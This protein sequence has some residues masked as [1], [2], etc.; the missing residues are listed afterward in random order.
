MSSISP[1]SSLSFSTL[2]SSSCGNGSGLPL[3]SMMIL[4][5]TPPHWSKELSY[6][7]FL[8][9]IMLF[10]TI[11]TVNSLNL[12]SLFPEMYQ[13][14]EERAQAN[15]MRQILLMVGL[16]VAAI[17]PTLFIEELTGSGESNG[18]DTVTVGQYQIAGVVLAVVVFLCYAFGLRWGVKERPTFESDHLSVPESKT[19]FIQC[20]KNRNFQW[21]LLCNLANWYVLMML[22]AIVPLYAEIV[23][24]DAPTELIGVMLGITFISAIIFMSLWRKIADRLQ[25]LRMAWMLSQTSWI[26]CLVPFFIVTNAWVAVICFFFLGIGLAGAFYLKD[27]IVSDIVDED[28]LVTGVRREGAYYGV[29]AFVMRLSTIAVFVSIALVLGGFG[30]EEFISPESA[31]AEQFEDF[32]FGLRLLFVAFPALALLIGILTISRYDLYGSKLQKIKTELHQLHQKKDAK[33]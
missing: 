14:E 33:A 2:R 17:T 28:E 20:L 19:A 30:L 11:Y 4:L 6:V 12:T 15:T 23:L 5:W 27:L 1:S 3:A 31:T 24:E 29:N 13:S 32:R 9:V 16:I 21:F 26:V 8:L 10:D 7:Y 25:D 18:V 22:S